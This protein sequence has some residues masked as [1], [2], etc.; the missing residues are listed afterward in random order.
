MYI[1]I[2]ICIHIY[3]YMCIYTFF[4]YSSIILQNLGKYLFMYCPSPFHSVHPTFCVSLNPYPLSLPFNFFP[5]GIIAD[6]TTAVT[7]TVN[8]VATFIAV[9]FADS[10]G[11]RPLMIYGSFGMMV[12][13]FIVGALVA[14][15]N[16]TEVNTA[17]SIA[18]FICLFIVNFA[19]SMG[20]IAWLYPAEIFPLSVRGK[21]VSISTSADWLANFAVSGWKL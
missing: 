4:Y 2:H 19:Y 10:L 13:L 16:V 14:G 18:V 20:P 9:I 11:R 17:N 5:L 21:G 1:C 7:G 3:I 12:C 8:V 6:T 15:G